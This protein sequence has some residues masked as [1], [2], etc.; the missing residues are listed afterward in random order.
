MRIAL[1]TFQERISPRFDCANTL[2]VVEI[3]DGAEVS[4]QEQM[5]GNMPSGHRVMHL[6]R[7]GVNV[8]LCGGLHRRLA[9]ELAAAGIEVIGGLWGEAEAI[10]QAYLRGELTPISRPAGPFGRGRG[11][12]RMGHHRPRFGRWRHGR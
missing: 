4:R 11:R 6:R 1:P 7:L 12:G 3:A 5:L 8:L 9:H 10:I 2:L